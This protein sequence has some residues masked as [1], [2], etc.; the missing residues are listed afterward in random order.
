ME[1]EL[2]QTAG[3]CFGVNRAVKLVFQLA[4]S[5]KPVCT[6]GPIIHNTRI[7][8]E[9]M[10][11][12]VQIVEK[13][14]DVPAGHTVVIRSHGAG[15]DVYRQLALAG[16]AV[17]DATC[18]F[19]AK[20]H[21]IVGDVPPGDKNLI[22]VAGDANHPEVEGIV[23]H[24]N[25]PCHV[26]SD[27]VQ[28][29]ETLANTQGL[30]D[31]FVTFVAQTTFNARKWKLMVD[32][33]K[34]V[35]TNLGIFDTICNATDS[36]QTEAEEMAKRSDLMIVAG[37][38]HSANTTRLKEVCE[39]ICP[40]ILVESARELAGYDFAG[41]RKVGITAGASTPDSIIKEVL[42]AMS[43]NENAELELSFAEM[44]EQ[45]FKSTYN[46]E[47]V[48]AV[49]TGIKPNEISVDIGTKHAGYVPLD[50]LTDNPALSPEDIVKVGDKLEVLV[51]RV[52]DVEGT[53]MLSKRRLEAQAGF[54]KVMGAV[55]TEEIL[56]GV[57]AEA[58]KGGV[59]VS[60]NG[61]RV[62]VP[63]SL[64]GLPRDA[65]LSQMIK[66]PVRFKILEVN[67]Q[68]RRAVG[69]IAAVQREERKVLAE[70][71]WEDVAEDKVYQGVVKS[72]TNFGV[73]V[74]LGGVDGRISL[75][76]LTW[77]KVKH[78]SEV[79]SLGETV[80][81]T[82]KEIDRENQKI[83]LIYK[84]SEDNPWEKIRSTFAVGDVAKVKI[85]SVTAFGAFA[86]LLPGLDGLIHI[87][88]IARERVEK[89][90]DR[91]HVGD[92]VDVKITEIDY[93]RRRIS[94]SMRALL[95]EEEPATEVTPVEAAPQVDEAVA[96]EAPKAK[97]SAAKKAPK[98]EEAAD[99]DR[100]VDAAEDSP[101]KEETPATEEATEAA[102]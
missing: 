91:L 68:R 102:E 43:T 10:A 29:A 25:A 44:L 73:F 63:A 40:T 31:I 53:V 21:R 99:V 66:K 75:M 39:G 69:S 30:D 70:K 8:D 2:C 77:N 37:G 3:F 78:P 84:K 83:S 18:P 4:D 96:E 49:V 20:I 52:N 90:A 24:C 57:V 93:D 33:A 41:I 6:W 82:I 23:G 74:D 7:V 71:F 97:K 13:V 28:L 65:D 79:V 100:V 34:K 11:K 17:E 60:T 50:E 94:L 14:E 61:V 55:D 15:R 42:E 89:V 81:V 46:G 32:H 87:S 88:Q 22:L 26:V 72:I 51:V 67:R 101:A 45:S 5:G 36:R 56:E 76:D 38:R 1:I 54:E 16:C 86:Q 92:E 62:F 48:T 95:P 35:C 64:T 12:G 85:M 27:E 59:L 98:A 47:K 80:E 9:L 58:V 19:V